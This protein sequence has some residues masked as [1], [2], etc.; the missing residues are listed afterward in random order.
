MN[1]SLDGSIRFLKEL[2]QAIDDYNAK[3][4]DD[5]YSKVEPLVDPLMPDGPAS[6][7]AI[8]NYKTQSKVANHYLTTN[9]RKI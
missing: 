5:A 4:G 1:K 9:R 3:F 6:L 7:Q 8:K 2:N